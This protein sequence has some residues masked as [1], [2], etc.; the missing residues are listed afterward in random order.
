VVVVGGTVEVV[1]DVV[2]LVVLV[3][4]V[5]V[6]V[7]DVGDRVVDVVVGFGEVVVVLVVGPPEWP[8]PPFFP[9]LVDFVEEDPE[10]SPGLG[11]CEVPFTCDAREAEASEADA[12]K[13]TQR[14]NA[15]LI[16]RYRIIAEPIPHDGHR[17]GRGPISTT[18]LLRLAIGA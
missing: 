16:S 10:A 2:V 13:A 7:V 18:F 4:D 5:V 9:F 3:V 14:T 1:V 15:M 6:L 8:W 11:W 12:A 17:N